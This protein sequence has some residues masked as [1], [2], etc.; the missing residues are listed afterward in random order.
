[1]N[2]PQVTRAELPSILLA[3]VDAVFPCAN[4][5]ETK[6]KY[7]HLS[8]VGPFTELASCLIDEHSGDDEVERHQDGDGTKA[9]TQHDEHSP[10][11][12][13]HGGREAPKTWKK[14]YPD[15]VGGLAEFFPMLNATR[16]FRP[17]VENHHRADARAQK[18]QSN[19]AILGQPR[20]NHGESDR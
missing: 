7:K 10:N 14:A 20:E 5:D 9:K 13:H 6:E 11:R 2:K 18:E 4:E 12:L 17:T 16:K 3:S 1:M 19:I 8:R 15:R